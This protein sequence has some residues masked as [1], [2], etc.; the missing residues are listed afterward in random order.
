M[1]LI[2]ADQA[3]EAGVMP[4][5]AMF[6]AMGEFNEALVKAGVMLAGD[7]LKPSARGARVLFSGDQRAVV[8]GP[9]PETRQLVCGFW[10]WQCPSLA[11]AIDWVKRCPSPL[12][13]DAE[14]EIRPLYE[15]EDFGPELTDELREQELRLRRE[16]EA[17]AK[18]SRS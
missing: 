15:I 9:F 4:S 14:I 16:S 1:I 12:L 11:D 3:T 7:G 17:L 6:T 2:K 10:L 13:G 8:P 18:A 5:E